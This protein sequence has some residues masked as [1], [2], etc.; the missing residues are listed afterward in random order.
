MAKTKTTSIIFVQ[1][2]SFKGLICIFV[3]EAIIVYVNP[4]V[5]KYSFRALNL[6]V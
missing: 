5:A 1:N 2:Y 3:F 4:K 6:C